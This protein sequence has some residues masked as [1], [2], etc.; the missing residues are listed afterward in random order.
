VGV[1]KMPNDRIPGW[2]R[3]VRTSIGF[4]FV[5]FFVSVLILFSLLPEGWAEAY[6]FDRINEVSLTPDSFFM[7]LD[8]YEQDI[9]QMIL[10]YSLCNPLN[11]SLKLSDILKNNLYVSAGG[12]YS[13]IDI[14]YYY[15][16]YVDSEK[17]VFKEV[18]LDYN[19]TAKLV[20]YYA[21]NEK[22]KKKVLKKLT[23]D[24]ALEPHTCIQVRQVAVGMP[25]LRGA[26]KLDIVPL[27]EIPAK[28]LNVKTIRDTDTVLFEQKRW[29]YWS[30]YWNNVSKIVVQNYD[31][32]SY[33]DL[34]VSF[35]VGFKEK[36]DASEF[37]ILCNNETVPFA[38]RKHND[39][40]FDFAVKVKINALGTNDSCRLYWNPNINVPEKNVS[41][42]SVFWNFYFDMNRDWQNWT[43]YFND[44]N[45]NSWQVLNLSGEYYLTNNET[46]GITFKGEIG[47]PILMMFRGKFT[48]KN[49]FL[50]ACQD[51]EFPFNNT[52]TITFNNISGSMKVVIQK[53]ISDSFTKLNES[54][55]NFSNTGEGNLTWNNERIA[56]IEFNNEVVIAH[57]NQ[58][59]SG[60]SGFHGIVGSMW[61]GYAWKYQGDYDVGLEILK[62][63]TTEEELPLGNISEV[64]IDWGEPTKVYC[65]ADNI[66][67]KQWDIVMN[68]KL[69][70]KVKNIYCENGCYRGACNLPN[71]LYYLIFGIVFAVAFYFIIKLLS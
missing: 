62:P 3:Y 43:S 59:S 63:Y 61:Q 6:S 38:V 13:P 55:Y 7:K 45:L 60:Y 9:N 17:P 57:D 2:V 29:A 50:F 33:P 67:T 5:V 32:I 47:D 10:D 69:Y 16:D 49:R 34:P 1:K 46:N 66:L 51:Y 42:T 54:H 53:R 30:V 4:R 23:G 56:V 18:K 11:E 35:R 68:N 28:S 25:R 70:R 36:Q 27:V 71:Y 58:Y 64:D 15:W 24:V 65:S 39:Y 8:T 22:Y 19:G 41:W 12:V 14:E 31:N 40:A 37:R 26:S 52:Y 48:E 44:A 20:L 21:G